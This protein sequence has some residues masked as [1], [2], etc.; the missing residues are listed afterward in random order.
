MRSAPLVPPL[1]CQGIKTK[2]VSAIDQIASS[3]SYQRWIEPFCGSCVVA[4]NMQ[5]KRAL[6]CDTNPHIIGLYLEVQ[7]ETLTPRI[8]RS[9]LAEQGAILEI[10][11][12]EYFYEVRKRFNEQPNSLDFLFLN[13]SCFN[14]IMRFNGSGKF[15]VPFGHKPRR[16]S[17]AYVTKICNQV[18]R[19]GVVSR[20]NDWVFAVA[21]FRATI[22]QAAP[23]DLLYCDPPYAGR[24]ADYFNRWSDRDESELGRLLREGSSRFILSTWY[25]NRHRT[26]LS[27]AENW[28]AA[29]INVVKRDHFYHV[30]ASENLRNPMIEALVTNVDACPAIAEPIY[31]SSEQMNLNLV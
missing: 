31:S 6:L 29:G 9:F 20:D 30:G 14:G 24:H 5:P 8:V 26:N 12:K 13:R 3:F 28:T 11:G 10:R 19:I 7:N 27:I 23:G 22:C 21:D 17:K 2:L 16:F 18:R 1:K 25:S 4:F 15:N